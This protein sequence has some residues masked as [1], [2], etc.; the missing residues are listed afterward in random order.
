MYLPITLKRKS[1]KIVKSWQ[2]NG[3]HNLQ[4]VL[5]FI[6]RDLFLS[7]LATGSQRQ[8]QKIPAMLDEIEDKMSWNAL[9]RLLYGGRKCMLIKSV[10]ELS[11]HPE[12]V[13]MI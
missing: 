9:E 3:A 12:Q 10:S 7:M 4:E 1:G 13:P 6:W 2:I 11:S 5:Q 8:I